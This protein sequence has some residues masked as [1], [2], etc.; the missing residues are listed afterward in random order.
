MGLS[1]PSPWLAPSL[2]CNVEFLPWNHL[3]ACSKFISSVP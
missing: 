1:L 2:P 3:G